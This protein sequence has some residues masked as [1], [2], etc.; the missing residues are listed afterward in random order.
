V[1]GAAGAQGPPGSAGTDGTAGAAGA[2]GPAGSAGTDGAAGA[3]GAEG[4]AG[5]AGGSGPQGAKGDKGDTGPT[6]PAG[7][8]GPKGDTGAQ[9]PAGTSGGAGKEVYL[10]STVA[11][12]ADTTVAVTA[13][14]LA[15]GTYVLDGRTR[16]LGNGSGSG[17]WDCSLNGD[18]AD[19]GAG[20]DTD[21]G[22]FSTQ[23]TS[24]TATTHLLLTL[25]SASTVVLRCRISG[26]SGT[27]GESRIIALALSSATRVAG[28][29]GASGS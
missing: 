26:K 13:I 14:N 11:I 28:T 1:N 6:G 4:P 27:A 21:S 20:D 29:A 12:P 7:P 10:E 17:S 25:G 8:Q 2:Q 9:G 16:L 24:A 5:A 15:A 18:P 3:A 22:T 19:S 23:Q